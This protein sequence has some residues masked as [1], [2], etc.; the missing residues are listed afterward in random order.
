MTNPPQTALIGCGRWGRNHARTLAGLGA[1]AAVSDIDAQLA[2]R[3]GA[4]HGVPA[5]PVDELMAD[6]DVAALVIALPAERHAAMAVR[7]FGARKHVLVE[8]PMALTAVDAQ[9]MVDAAKAAGRVLMTGHILRYHA[10]FVALRQAVGDGRIGAVR[11]IH[12]SRLGFG[13]FFA[14]F[15]AMWDLAPHDLSLVLSLADAAPASVNA[16]TVS[17]TGRQIDLAHIALA[18]AEHDLTAHVHVSR[19]SAVSERRLVVTGETGTL[20][21]DD[22]AGWPEKL[23][24]IRHEARRPRG[25]GWQWNREDAEHLPVAESE[26]LALE[27]THF[28]ACARTGE[29]PLTPGTQGL[30]VVRI[31][32]KASAA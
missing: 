14:R 12:S 10:A 16:Q 7:A 22:L 6:G 26:P 13:K 32:E 15:D 19:H 29:T 24:L 18:F 25:E 27:L 2:E 11:H 3:V 9:A 31:L 28:L 20:I 23:G 17:L 4:D 30:E 5:R 21:W 1:L 8:K